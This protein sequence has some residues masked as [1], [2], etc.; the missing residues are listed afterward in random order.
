MG[1]QR[2]LV[3]ITEMNRGGAEA[4]LMNYYRHFDRS[5]VQYDFVVNREARGAYEDEIQ[6]LGGRIY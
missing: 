5:V 3:L 1:V 4:F 2:V 6:K